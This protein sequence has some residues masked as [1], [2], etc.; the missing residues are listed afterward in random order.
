MGSISGRISQSEFDGILP[1]IL[2]MSRMVTISSR[3]GNIYS[4]HFTHREGNHTRKAEEFMASVTRAHSSQ[5]RT[6]NV[7]HATPPD[8]DQCGRGDRWE[9]VEDIEAWLHCPLGLCPGQRV[10]THMLSVMPQDQNLVIIEG[11]KRKK[12]AQHLVVS[13]F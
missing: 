3:I 13:K 9:V 1:D 11:E 4:N 5:E 8:F 6:S 10:G 12:N 7:R 2:Q